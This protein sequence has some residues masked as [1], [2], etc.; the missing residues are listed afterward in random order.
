[1]VDTLNRIRVEWTGWGG[2]PAVST[3]YSDGA[4]L[5]NLTD[6]RTFYLALAG[7]IPTGI[8]IQVKGEG[9]KIR[10]SDGGLVGSWVGTAPAAVS[11]TGGTSYSSASGA[12][13]TWLTDTI[14]G[15]R[16]LKGKTFIVPL[17]GGCYGSNGRISSAVVTVLQNAA[18]TFLNSGSTLYQV[19][20][21]PGPN[22]GGMSAQMK[23]A[24]VTD[25]PSVLTS[26]RD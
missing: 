9:D 11:C 10:S 21:R 13:V 2:G 1:M 19:W 25:L 20:G 14:H 3:F 17:G 16:R 23:T 5:P 15:R 26:R 4:A 6:L 22:G 24:K 7:Q 8:S 18:T 12:H